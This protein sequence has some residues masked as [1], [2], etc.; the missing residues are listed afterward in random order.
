MKTPK[1][2]IFVLMIFAIPAFA[3]VPIKITLI[4]NTSKEQQ[5]KAQLERLVTKYDLSPWLFTKDID[6]NEKE[7]IPFSHPKLTVNHRYLDNDNAQ[8]S[9]FLHEQFHW[10]EDQKQKNF[11]SAIAEFKMLYPEVPVG[12]AGGA[13]DTYS[14]YLHLV[15]CDLEFQVM[16][17]L[18]GETEARKIISGW[19][20]YTWIY[21]KVLNDQRVREIVKKHDLLIP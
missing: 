15:V 3:Q 19:K 14:T 7:W 10:W 11:E 21:E 13:K 12:K 9:T 16:T 1:K 4:N 5:A 17:K 8:L 20:H 6:I 2:L 18:T